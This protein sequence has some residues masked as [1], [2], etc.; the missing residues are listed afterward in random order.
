MARVAGACCERRLGEWPSLGS[1]A[2]F[3]DG[4]HWCGSADGVV[5]EGLSAACWCCGY[6]PALFWVKSSE[7]IEN[8]CLRLALGNIPTFGPNSSE[9]HENSGD[10]G[11]QR[12]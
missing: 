10:D 8:K 4:A 1:V 6:F 7:V 12:A 3:G 2:F 11:V 5:G 9:L